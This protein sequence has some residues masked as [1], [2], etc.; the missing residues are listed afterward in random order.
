[1]P[2][3]TEVA[4]LE[5]KVLKVPLRDVD[6]VTGTIVKF[7]G[8]AWHLGIRK[9]NEPTSRIR[10]DSSLKRGVEA[11][12][13][14]EGDMFQK[15]ASWKGTQ[16]DELDWSRIK[17]L[18]TR[19][20]LEHRKQEGRNAQQTHAFDCPNF[21]KHVSY[22]SHNAETHLLIPKSSPCVMMSGSSKRT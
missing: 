13:F 6:S 9:G 21:V 10:L 8:P 22:K 2:L 12:K 1:M 16:W 4:E 20:I 14:V 7:K 11:A 3:P 17:E 15:C 5:L 18:T 19:N